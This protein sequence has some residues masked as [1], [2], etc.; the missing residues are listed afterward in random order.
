MPTFGGFSQLP[1][2]KQAEVLAGVGAAIDAVGGQFTM[3]YATVV[4]TASR[5]SAA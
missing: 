3:H 1:P 4:A 5:T 2:G